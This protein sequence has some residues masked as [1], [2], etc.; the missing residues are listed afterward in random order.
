MFLGTVSPRRRRVLPRRTRVP[1]YFLGSALVGEGVL[2]LDE[3]VRLGE[4][5]LLLG[6]PGAFCRHCFPAILL[7]IM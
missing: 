2:R 3:V 1:T 4:G 6:K 7:Y 5:G